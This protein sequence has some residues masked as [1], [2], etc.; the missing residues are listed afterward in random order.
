MIKIVNVLLLVSM[1]GVKS[2]LTRRPS[3]D[4][5]MSSSRLEAILAEELSHVQPYQHNL[6]AY[7]QHSS[8]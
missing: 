2:E 4:T 8:D 6:F 3:R 7:T 1:D 5:I